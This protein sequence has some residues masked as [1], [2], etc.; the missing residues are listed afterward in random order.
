MTRSQTTRL[1]RAVPCAAVLALLL[2]LVPVAP[3][4]AGPL[5]R[6][7][8]A[9]LRRGGP[10][11]GALVVDADTGRT[12]YSRRATTGRI[13]A[14]VEKLWTTTAALRELGPRARLVTDVVATG[15]LD[16]RGVLHGGLWLRGGGDPTLRADD[17]DLLARRL[18]GAGVRQV[19][20]RV[21]GDESRFDFRRGVPSSGY[22]ASLYVEPL[23]GLAYQRDL[24][25]GRYVLQPAASAASALVDALARRRVR[26]GGYGAGRAPARTRVLASASSPSLAAII[27]ATNAPSDNFYAEMLLKNLGAEL[28]GTG[29]TAAG[30]RVVRA[31]AAS[32]GLHPRL[33]DGS[34]LSRADR[35]SPAQI[36]AL[37][38]AE[39]A[40]PS[41]TS[42][43]AVLGRSGTLVHRLRG[44]VAAGRCRGKT[45]TL[46][47]VSALV[48][49]CTA[50]S[51]RR[52]AFAVLMNRTVVYYA[53]LGQ[54]AFVRALFTYV[55]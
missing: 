43:L 8:D 16:G 18:A 30:A 33:Y 38:R 35:S 32:I 45:G 6:S 24:L 53:H 23:S 22:A 10:A 52:L 9:A 17:I 40:H 14:S 25:R 28:G 2:A 27:A 44:T 3:A 26:V 55:R 46:T 50:R 48:G 12:L 4:A 1:R 29:S 11:S 19:T 34:G 20:G 47:D 37:L 49:Y 42:S 36:V 15:R 31:S 13:P 54:D 39:R 21:L 41:F 7:L 5:S 51:G